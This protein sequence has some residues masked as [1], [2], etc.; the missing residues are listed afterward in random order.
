MTSAR[1][2][3]WVNPGRPQTIA[4]LSVLTI[5]PGSTP[6]VEQQKSTLNTIIYTALAVAALVVALFF[7]LVVLERNVSCS[8]PSKRS[9]PRPANWG[10]VSS[11]AVI[12]SGAVD[13]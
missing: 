10:W 3:S 6:G 13:A 2:P 12:A 1:S 11:Q 5:R 7:A 8:P 4:G 9:E